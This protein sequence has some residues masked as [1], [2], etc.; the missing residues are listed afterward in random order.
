MNFQKRLRA[1]MDQAGVSNTELAQHIGV[2]GQA[3]GKWLKK[4]TIKKDH[5]PVIAKLTGVDF[6]WLSTGEGTLSAEIPEIGFNL[7]IQDSVGEYSTTSLITPDMIK[8]LLPSTGIGALLIVTDLLND[9]RSGHLSESD[10]NTLK[11]VINKFR[12][13]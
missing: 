6:Q 1:A 2:S 7:G 10:L 8:P 9:L 12:N 13:Y 5:L 4:G 3:V 11:P